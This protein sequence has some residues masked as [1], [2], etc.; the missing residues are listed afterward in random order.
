M[1]GTTI[2][3]EQGSGNIY[4]DLELADA[5]DM[6]VKAK[7]AYKISEIISQRHLTQIAAADLIGLPQPKLSGMLRG[8]FRCISECKMLDCLNKLGL[9][10]TIEENI[11]KPRKR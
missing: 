5:E 7:L 11:F 4:A 8:Q 9:D 3:V 6:L 2:R 1:G 10:V